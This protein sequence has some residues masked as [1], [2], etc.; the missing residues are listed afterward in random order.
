[1][2]YILLVELIVFSIRIWVL[3][4]SCFISF[5]Y[6]KGDDVVLFLIVFCSVVSHVKWYGF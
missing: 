2:Y 3:W 5:T 1:M 6:I 4:R